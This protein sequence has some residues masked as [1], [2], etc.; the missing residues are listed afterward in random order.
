MY[1]DRAEIYQ[2][3]L[4][5]M[6]LRHPSFASFF[7]STF[8]FYLD[9]GDGLR[10]SP[11]AHTLPLPVLAMAKSALDPYSI[12]IPELYHVLGLM[13]SDPQAATADTAAEMGNGMRI[14]WEKGER[15][16]CSVRAG[17]M[18][19]SRAAC[20]MASDPQAATADTAAEMGN[21]M[22]GDWVTGRQVCG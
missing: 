1:P 22:R 12:P 11:R 7:S 13:A 16:R 2:I 8:H 19:G 3:F 10:Q 18:D 5:R 21:G 15:K 14:D 20:T 17:C 4:S 9:V 6:I